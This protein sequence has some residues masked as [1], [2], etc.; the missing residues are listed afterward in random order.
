MSSMDEGVQRAKEG[1]YAFIGESVSLD[2]AVARHCELVRAHEVV[3]M[4]GYSIAAAIGEAAESDRRFGFTRADALMDSPVPSPGSPVIKNL[5]I[6]I[7]QLNEAGELAYLRSKW[8]ASSCLAERAM[9][10]SMR[11][12]GLRGAFLVLAIGLG[13]GAVAALLELASKSRRNAAE[14]KVS[15]VCDERKHGNTRRSHAST[16]SH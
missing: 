1:N 5:S 7:L 2:L 8:W 15:F 6:A 4:R 16:F 9:S 14:Q 10:S 11:P 12:H 3:G 13:L